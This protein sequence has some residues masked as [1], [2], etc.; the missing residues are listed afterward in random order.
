M[1]NTVIPNGILIIIFLALSIKVE[2]FE[3]DAGVPWNPGSSSTLRPLP[4][5]SEA[6]ST[7]QS[8]EPHPTHDV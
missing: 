5:S 7:V 1:A 2:V 8:G 4:A 6:D 3:L